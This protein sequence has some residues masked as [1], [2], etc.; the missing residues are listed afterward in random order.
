MR[1]VSGDERNEL[2]G[3]VLAIVQEIMFS[4]LCDLVLV[5]EAFVTLSYF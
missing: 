5:A 4:L 3:F 1:V 2:C